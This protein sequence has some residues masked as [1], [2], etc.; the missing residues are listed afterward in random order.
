MTAQEVQGH[1]AR[2]PPCFG[3]NIALAWAA[4]NEG[5]CRPKASNWV[6]GSSGLVERGEL[7]LWRP[8][9]AP[10]PSNGVQKIPWASALRV[11]AGAILF[12]VL[13]RSGIVLLVG[14]A[15][16]SD[17]WHLPNGTLLDESYHPA[18]LSIRTGRASTPSRWSVRPA[19]QSASFRPCCATPWSPA[20]TRDSTRTVRSTSAPPCG[21]RGGP[22]RATCKAAARS[23]SSSPARCCSK[24]TPQLR[25]QAA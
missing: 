18:S 17:R 14:L 15:A 1:L 13:I 24:K 12:T 22:C 19:W 23:P 21:P 8:Q 16:Q 25:A 4:L 3:L 20:R 10:P 7:V 5:K 6:T 11:L 9:P 2:V